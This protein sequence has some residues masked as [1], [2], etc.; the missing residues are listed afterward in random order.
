MFTVNNGKRRHDNR[1]T[2]RPSDQPNSAIECIDY[3]TEVVS[4]RRKA[5]CNI[6]SF[7]AL[8]SPTHP[9]AATPTSMFICIDSQEPEAAHV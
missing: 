9:P 7:G 8:N 6:L 5:H 2:E 4:H 3:E 1:R